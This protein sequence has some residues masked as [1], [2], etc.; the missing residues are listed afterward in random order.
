MKLY[1]EFNNLVSQGNFSNIFSAT[2]NQFVA[3]SISRD[4]AVISSNVT[5]IVNFTTF[6]ALTSGDQIQIYISNELEKA[7]GAILCKGL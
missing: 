2:P 1:D 6:N 4:A 3:A 5:L 7:N